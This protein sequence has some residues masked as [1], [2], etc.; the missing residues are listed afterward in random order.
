MPSFMDFPPELRNMVYELVLVQDK[1]ISFGSKSPLPPDS[2][3]INRVPTQHLK[4]LIPLTQ[5]SRQLRDETTPILFA[6]NTFKVLLSTKKHDGPLTQFARQLRS[7]NAPV[8]FD[9]LSHETQPGYLTWGD[10]NAA[11]WAKIAR[12]EALMRIRHLCVDRENADTIPGWRRMAHL[13][14]IPNESEP[15]STSSFL[16]HEWYL[17]AITL[18][19]KHL[20]CTTWDIDFQEP[21]LHCASTRYTGFSSEPRS[22]NGCE[23]CWRF[24]REWRSD[25][26]RGGGVLTREHFL[27]LVWYV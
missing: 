4:T 8:L 21:F 14:P 20:V 22:L 3:G 2:P 27:K 12:E 6:R 23:K 24:L 10:E 7:S 18:K 9:P 26:L 15:T 17:H 19:C 16:P 13:Y 25:H 5:V 1:T 11:L